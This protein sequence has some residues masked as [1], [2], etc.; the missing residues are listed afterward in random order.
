MSRICLVCISLR[1]GGTER[2]VCRIANQLNLKNEISILLLSRNK[3]FYKPDADI[4]VICPQ[5]SKRSEAG[6][7]WYPTILRY[8]WR[9]LGKVDPDLVL[10]FGELIAPVVLPTARLQGRRTLMFNRASP[11]TCLRGRRGIINP[12]TYPLAHRVVVQTERSTR[13]LRNR[14]RFSNFEVLPN[15]VEIP[16]HVRPITHRQKRV[17]NVGTLGGHKNQQA[18]LRAFSE[19]RS[20]TAWSL[21]FVGDGPNRQ[22]LESLRCSLGLQDSVHF[23]GQRSDV[24]ELLQDSPIFAFTSLTEGFPNALAEAMAAGC[25]C[26]S[27]DCPTGPSELIEHGVNGFLVEPGN[28]TEYSRLLQELIEKPNLRTMFSRNARRSMSR[29]EAGTVMRRLEKM[30]EQAVG[31]DQT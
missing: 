25:A 8:L 6:W 16:Q 24:G 10:C 28:E 18:L 9:E 12:L 14:F 5:A 20:G 19:I 30:I 23:L 29:F 4:S 26:I 13:L 7:R 2:I 17:I 3:P 21:E 11:L 1:A 27:Y 22:E 15:P 31:L